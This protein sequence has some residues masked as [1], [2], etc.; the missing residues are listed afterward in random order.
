MKLN[1]LQLN[2]LS[3]IVMGVKNKA[4]GKKIDKPGELIRVMPSH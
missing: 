3:V 4:G 2:L 1:S